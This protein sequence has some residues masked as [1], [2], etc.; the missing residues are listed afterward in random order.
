MLRERH[1]KTETKRKRET[2][3]LRDYWKVK[4]LK[5]TQPR[6]C[7]MGSFSGKFTPA[8]QPQRAHLGQSW[9]T[10]NISSFWLAGAFQLA[11]R[12]I[13]LLTSTSSPEFCSL[14]VYPAPSSKLIIWR[15]MATFNIISGN[16]TSKLL[17]HKDNFLHSALI[18]F[19]YHFFADGSIPQ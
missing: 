1:R 7:P 11:S 19:L 18:Q 8:D 16:D 10:E 15:H 3:V 17:D 14:S 12:L 9:R 5:R 13:N 6:L 4:D 2:R